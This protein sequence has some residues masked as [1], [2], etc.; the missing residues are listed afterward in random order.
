MGKKTDK[1]VIEILGSALQA[2]SDHL[3]DCGYGDFYERGEAEEAGLDHTIK[4][5][6]DLV[7][8]TYTWTW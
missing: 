6:L 4:G 5:A 7:G 8:G 1:E 2:A 3:A